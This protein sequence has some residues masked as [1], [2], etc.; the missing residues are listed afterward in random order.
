MKT[1]LISVIT[2]DLFMTV[3]PVGAAYVCAAAR[4]AGH[5]VKM[6]SLRPAGKDFLEIMEKEI[7]HFNPDVIGISM[8]NVDDQS[9]KDTLFLLKPV[10]KVVQACRQLSEAP[11]VMGG[12]GYSIFPVSAL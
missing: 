8:R 6:L 3:L 11:I 4:N 1:L 10:K 2:E 5:D 9:M 12:A 7:G